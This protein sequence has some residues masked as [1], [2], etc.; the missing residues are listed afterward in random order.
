MAFAISCESQVDRYRFETEGSSQT[1]GVAVKQDY[2]QTE[3]V[4]KGVAE[5]QTDSVEKPERKISLDNSTLTESRDES[6]QA[7][8]REKDANEVFFHMVSHE[9]FYH[10]QIDRAMLQ[11]EL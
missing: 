5:I 11:N 6:K 9:C 7:S 4:K 10:S 3:T 8:R 1:A 2:V